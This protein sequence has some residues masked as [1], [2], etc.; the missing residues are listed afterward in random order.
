[1]IADQ[2]RRVHIIGHMGAHL[3]V[4]FDLQRGSGNIVEQQLAG[5]GIPDFLWQSLV[6][7]DDP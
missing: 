2:C 4:E 7:I 3:V 5:T 6:E 1:M